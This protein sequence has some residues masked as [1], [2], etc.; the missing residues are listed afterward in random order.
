[1]ASLIDKIENYQFIFVMYLMR[2]LLGMTNELS[3][4]LQQ[5]DQNIVQAMRLIEVV[6]ARLQHFKETGWEEFL[7][8]VS[9]FTRE[10]QSQCLI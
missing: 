5:K 8:E 9:L 4:A 3:L 1:M 7:V 2:R 10:T 6:K